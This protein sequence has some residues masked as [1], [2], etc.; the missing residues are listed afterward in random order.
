MHSFRNLAF[1][2]SIGNSSRIHI[3]VFK[4]FKKKDAFPGS[5]LLLR[6]PSSPSWSAS[7][8]NELVCG[9]IECD[10]LSLDSSWRFNVLGKKGS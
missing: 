9:S 8:S 6:G 5:G 1:Y 2:A 7:R 4:A 3:L 10:S